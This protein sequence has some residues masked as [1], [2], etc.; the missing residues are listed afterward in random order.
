MF[1]VF[2][3]IEA[4]IQTA[5]KDLDTRTMANEVKLLKKCLKG[6]SRAFEIIVAEYQGL[7]CAITYSGIA[8]VQRS[9]ELA[10][11]TFINA[12]KNLSQ[13]K[14][15]S[16][17][18][19]WLCTIARNNIRNFINKNKRDILQK[20]KPMENVNDTAADDSGPLESV[21][22]KEHIELVNAA[23][24]RIPERYREPLVLYYRQQQSVKQ[25]AQSLDLSEEIVKKRLQRGRE[26]IKAQLSSIVEETLSATGPKKA[27]TALVMG[28]IAGIAIK[29]SG[30]AAAAMIAGTSTT[31][32]VVSTVLGTVAGKIITAAAVVAIGVGSVFVYKQVTTQN[33]PDETWQTENIAAIQQQQKAETDKPTA[34]TTIISN[35]DIKKDAGVSKTALEER[36]GIEV[37][38]VEVIKDISV[39]E[40]IAEYQFKPKGV[41][42][43]LITDI[44]TGEPVTDAEVTISPGRLYRT[45]TNEN[46]FYTSGP[47]IQWID[48][49]YGLRFGHLCSQPPSRGRSQYQQTMLYDTL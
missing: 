7:V 24:G 6:D 41:L 3:I 43:G 5:L 26:K 28:S 29:G 35:E 2:F 32:G 10:H 1:C 12:W 23:I 19:P 36:K 18:R 16:R 34:Q 46:G 33:T 47:V 9:E 42:S 31:T 15:L 38:P 30:V 22:K 21:I 8:D 48:L 37:D 40:T 27:F 39:P 25:V 14:D 13:L 20:A 17:F 4:I 45:K 44:K 49:G 11:Q